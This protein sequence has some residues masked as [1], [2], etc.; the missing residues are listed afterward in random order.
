MYSRSVD[1][2]TI[3]V[4]M[5]ARCIE[6]AGMD[7][8]VERQ[9]IAFTEASKVAVAIPVEPEMAPPERD[10][11]DRGAGPSRLSGFP[12]ERATRAAEYAKRQD[13]RDQRATGER[14]RAQPR[15]KRRAAGCRDQSQRHGHC[16]TPTQFRER[17]PEADQ[18][19]R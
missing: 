1:A 10:S 14:P 8:A 4:A 5:I 19:E 9:A 17:L 7:R 12:H 11:S 18:H 2:V 16:V 3:L 15:R 13:A 6:S